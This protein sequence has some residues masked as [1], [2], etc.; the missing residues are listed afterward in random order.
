M[1]GTTEMRLA[2][3]VEAEK[4]LIRAKYTSSAPNREVYWQPAQ[5]YGNHLKKYSEA[6][7]ELENYVKAQT[8]RSTPEKRKKPRITEN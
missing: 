2:K 4:H 5:L 8:D 6:A 1:L 7:Y 3:Y